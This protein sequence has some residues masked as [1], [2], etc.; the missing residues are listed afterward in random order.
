MSFSKREEILH[1]A[2]EIFYRDGFRATGMDKLVKETGISKTSMYK[3]FR[4]KDELILASL[5]LR[6][7]LFRND[8]VRKI[9]EKGTDPVT[10]ILGF[11]DILD[12]W[13]HDPEFRSCMFIKATSEYPERGQPINNISAEH[14]NL[15]GDYIRKLVIKTGAKNP[16]LLTQQILLL[17]EGAIVTA[18]MQ[19]PEGVAQNAKLTTSTLIS[20]SLN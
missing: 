15:F 7:E 17:K 10:Q 8:L 9:E 5:R 12:D 16:E 11:F 2:L 20:A 4:T 6:D 19:G 14:K 1:K 13:F 3:Y 18:H